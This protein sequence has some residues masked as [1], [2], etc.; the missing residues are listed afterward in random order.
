MHLKQ[1]LENN[2]KTKKYSPNLYCQV[3]KQHIGENGCDGCIASFIKKMK[4]D[5]NS[6][7]IT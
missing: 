2:R 7:I 3:H 4:I 1:R 6:V 5:I